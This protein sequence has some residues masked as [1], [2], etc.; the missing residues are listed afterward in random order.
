MSTFQHCPRQYQY[1]YLDKLKTIPDQSPDNA[2]Y[3]GTAIHAGLEHDLET[4]IETY[5][6]NYY[7]LTTEHYNEIIKLE[8]LI[9]KCK[10][11]LPSGE[12]EVKIEAK[13][14]VGYIDLL[15]DDWIIDYKYSNN[16]ENYL[17]SPQ[18][19]LYKFFAHRPINRLSYLFIPKIRI[20]Q[21]KTE[22]IQEFR[23]RLYEELEYAEP[24]LVDV[25]YDEGKVREW[26]Q[27][28]ETVATAKEFPR[29]Q[30]RLCGWC[31]YADYCLNEQDWM[32]Y[33]K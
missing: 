27:A 5:K 20:R 10:A 14:Y 28:K 18:I 21:K 23:M 15:A 2:L 26:L 8:V 33:K 22:S 24:E 19:H 32:I 29:N 4:A 3:L 25:S 7:M 31:E 11:I 12:H 13:G 30:T 16:R 1:R 17:N 6:S 9:P